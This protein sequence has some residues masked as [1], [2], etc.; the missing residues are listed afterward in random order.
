MDDTDATHTQQGPKLTRK[1][2]RTAHACEPCRQRKSRCDGSRPTCDLC[3]EQGAECYY[4]DSLAMPAVAVDRQPLARLE[5]RL[6]DMEQ[7]LHRLVPGSSQGSILS[8]TPSVRNDAQAEAAHWSSFGTRSNDAGPPDTAQLELAPSTDSVDGM[9]SITFADETSSGIF[10]P[11]SNTAFL[12]KIVSAQRLMFGQGQ[13]LP[14]SMGDLHAIHAATSLHISRPTSPLP[15][16][17]STRRH[18]AHSPPT[19]NAYALPSHHDILHMVDVFFDNTGKFFPYLYK[20]HIL[21]NLANMRRTGFQNVERSQLCVLH[22]LMAFATTHCPSELPISVRAEMGDVF[23]QRALQLIP[24]IRPAAGN[25]DSIRSLLMATQYIQGTQRSSQTWDM[26]GNLIHAAFQVG[27]Y[28]D[29]TQVNCTPLES[30][31]RKRTWWMCFIMDRLC[32]MTNGR[33]QLVPNAY[34]TMDLPTDVELETLDGSPPSDMNA[35]T[36]STPSLLL[37]TSRLYLILGHIIE[38]VYD[39]NISNHSHPTSLNKLLE[40]VLEAEQDLTKWVQELPQALPQVTASELNRLQ[41]TEDRQTCRFRT[42]LTLRFLNVRTLLHRAVLSQLLEL[43]PQES[44]GTG[45]DFIFRMGA[46][47]VESCVEAAVESIGII[48]HATH[49][50]DLLPIWWYSVYFSFSAALAVYGSILAVHKCDIRSHRYASSY[51]V[52]KLQT[53][54][55]ALEKLGGE[56]RQV[57]RCRKIIRRLL[58]AALTLYPPTRTARG[59]EGVAIERDE[60]RSVPTDAALDLLDE[61]FMRELDSGIALDLSSFTDDLG[62][63][64][65]DAF[66]L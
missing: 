65:P 13:S 7:M 5:T 20:P 66:P 9:G 42:I 11:T 56:T 23:L 33:P 44:V 1:R 55:D 45:Q 49:Q 40:K 61:N 43:Q 53:A 25:L 8:P 58:Q 2:K 37:Y 10:G 48:S 22:L 3:D 12:Q 29:A 28:Q 57:L 41:G 47:S 26:L 38:T 64:I 46:S 24:D 19:V 60:A 27:L 31:L 39:N 16:E 36:A 63:L 50:Q 51:L 6:R 35:S 14:S 18:T 4:R 52:Q 54:L 32:S 15:P 17:L 59:E 62:S 34:M 21:R 30:E